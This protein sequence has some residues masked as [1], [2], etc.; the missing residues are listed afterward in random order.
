MLVDV[1]L[2]ITRVNIFISYLFYSAVP[3]DYVYIS[4]NVL[5]CN[6]LLID[7]HQNTNRTDEWHLQ[8]AVYT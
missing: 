2:I 8:V 1:N 6:N 4:A 5:A 7:P 3:G